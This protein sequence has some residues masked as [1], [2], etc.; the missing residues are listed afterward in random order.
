[1]FILKLISL[2]FVLSLVTY[3]NDES[4]PAK[5]LRPNFSTHVFIDMYNYSTL[6]TGL[7]KN[8][9]YVGDGMS[10]DGYDNGNILFVYEY[11]I[12]QVVATFY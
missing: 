4:I 10:S 5:P 1:M 12:E 11:K 6:L 2:S 3:L 8:G 9:K 7:D